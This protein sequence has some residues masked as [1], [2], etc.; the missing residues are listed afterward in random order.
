MC[1]APRLVQ[2]LGATIERMP[3]ARVRWRPAEVTSARD[4]TTNARPS[5]CAEGH[6]A[7]DTAIADP[8][9]FVS[10]DAAGFELQPRIP[11]VVHRHRYDLID[12]VTGLGSPGT[13]PEGGLN[14]LNGHARH[15]AEATRGKPGR[16]SSSGECEDL[17]VVGAGDTAVTTICCCRTK[18]SV[19]F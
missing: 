1:P 5:R 3:F 2:R 15:Q 18:F 6:A 13:D 16:A 14:G 10:S 4:F 8:I 7:G 9:D 12:D 19:S 17:R 11:A